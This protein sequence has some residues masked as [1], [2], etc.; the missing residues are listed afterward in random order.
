MNLSMMY[1]SAVFLKPQNMFCNTIN[2]EKVLFS[3][4]K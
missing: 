2:Y 4:E 1:S 3:Y